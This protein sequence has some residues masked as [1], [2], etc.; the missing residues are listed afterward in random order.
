MAEL[1]MVLAVIGT[2]ALAVLGAIANIKPDSNMIMF[3]KAFYITEKVIAEIIEDDAVYPKRAGLPGLFNSG[4][5]A[6]SNGEAIRLNGNIVVV[7]N[8]N[9]AGRL[10]VGANKFCAV[11]SV[12]VNTVDNI[13]CGQDYVGLTANGMGG[14]NFRTADGIVWSFPVRNTTDELMITIDTNGPKRPNCSANDVNDRN[15]KYPDR[16]NIFVK[17]S[18]GKISVRAGSM[19]ESYLKSRFRDKMSN[20]TQ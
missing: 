2:I 6:Y 18:N 10:A 13:N 9:N 4:T 15:C 17:S 12:K 5:T 16:F 11:F 7:N 14:G 20:K 3:K 19:E 1:L 8:N